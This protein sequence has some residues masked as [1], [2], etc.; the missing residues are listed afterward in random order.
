MGRCPAAVLHISSHSPTCDRWL[1]LVDL[2]KRFLNSLHSKGT[3]FVK[4]MGWEIS[5]STRSGTSDNGAWVVM[6]MG[7]DMIGSVSNVHRIPAT[8]LWFAAAFATGTE[9]RIAPGPWLSQ[10]V[11]VTSTGHQVASLK[12]F[13]PKLEC[14]WNTTLEL[15]TVDEY[16]FHLVDRNLHARAQV[17]LCVKSAFTP[18][19]WLRR[20]LDLS[21]VAWLCGGR[22]NSDLCF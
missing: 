11:A 9:V 17:F 4:Q 6:W 16:N 14:G 18:C 12:N 13:L 7:H 3:A 21:A 15:T 1:L 5:P 2:R 19:T 22:K 20:P 10:F 8:C